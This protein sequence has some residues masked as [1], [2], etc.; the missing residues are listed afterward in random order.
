MMEVYTLPICFESACTVFISGEYEVT[1]LAKTGQREGEMEGG[2]EGG[3]E[4]ERDSDPLR[5]RLRRPLFKSQL[6][7]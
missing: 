4:G 6:I 2:R 7:S 1:V 5:E 3:T